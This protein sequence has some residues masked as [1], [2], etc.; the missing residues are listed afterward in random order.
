MTAAVGSASVLGALVVTVCGIAALMRGRHRGPAGWIRSGYAAPVGLFVLV[1]VAVGALET[2]LVRSDFSIRYV[3]G[4]SNLV[5][6]LLFRIVTL[7]GALEGS[8][9]LW[10]WILA[11]FTLIVALRYRTRYP[12]VLPSVLSVLL[13]ISAFFLLLMAGPAN[14]FAQLPVPPA[15]GR[16]LNPLLQNHVLMII[17]PPLLYLG[18]VGFSV[19]FAFAMGSLFSGHLRDEWMAV[20]RRWSLAAW[21]FL[22]AGLFLGARWSYDVLGWGG[23]WSW[24]PVEN[25]AFMPW[26]VA[27][28]LIHSTMVQARRGLLRIWSLAL[29]ILTFLLTIFGTF[30]TRSGVLAS[31]HSFTQSLIGPLFLAFLAAAMM[32]SLGLLAARLPT[33][34]DDGHID[35]PLSREAMMVLNNVVLLAMAFTVFLGTVFPLAVEAISGVKVSVGPPF[36]NRMFVP[37]GSLLLLLMGL[38]TIFRWGQPGREEFRRLGL[39]AAAA[40]AAAVL[41]TVLGLREP[42]ITI[43]IAITVFMALAQL[44]EYARGVRARRAATGEDPIR[45]LAGLVISNRQR[46]GGYLIHL[47]LAVAVVGIIASMSSRVE[48]ERALSAGESFQIAGYT[49]RY[50]AL[51]PKPAPDRLV[52][53]AHLAVWVSN[54]RAMAGTRAGGPAAVVVA[55][56]LNFFPQDRTP[57]ATPAVRSSWREDLYLVLMG[58]DANGRRVVLNAIVNPLVSWIW[59]GGA[60][61]VVAGVVASWPSRRS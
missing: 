28:A 18:Y 29:V 35:S 17:H 26:L 39:V 61:M 1:S 4:N 2:A 24:D 59:T 9:L 52:V 51:I 15:D 31:V 34:R 48:V 19:P 33:V 37:L 6:P 53:A 42:L 27:T 38:G 22:T 11:L 10:Q 54:G 30:L 3:A 32:V 21:T 49:I 44:M 23:Y 57:V 13:A 50:D 55:P 58:V 25:A 43:G 8:I 12:D 20:T 47:G 45:A 5:T 40:A 36:F 14:P 60:I 7:W 16:G 41:L 56:S 46:Y